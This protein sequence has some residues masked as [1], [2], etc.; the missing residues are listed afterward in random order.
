MNDADGPMRI[1]LT[2]ERR[3]GILSALRRLFAEQ[4]DE[5][6]SEFR[7]ERILE[8]LLAHLGPA[9][10]NQA[11]Q[12]ARSFLQEHLN[13]LDAVFYEPPPED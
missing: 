13:D 4:F 12:D 10:Y 6:L 11:I 2:D 5:D 3:E 8:L 7:A 9:V 1:R